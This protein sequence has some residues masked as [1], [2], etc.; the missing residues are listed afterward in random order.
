M[1]GPR[2]CTSQRSGAPLTHCSVHLFRP[3]SAV[4]L[5]VR[6]YSATRSLH[7]CTY[8][9]CKRVCVYACVWVSIREWGLGGW[10][11]VDGVAKGKRSGHSSFN[12][13]PLGHVARWNCCLPGRKD[14]SHLLHMPPFLR[15]QVSGCLLAA[16]H[17][18]A[19]ALGSR[20]GQEPRG[21]LA[22]CRRSMGFCSA[23][24]SMPAPQ[25]SMR[26][27]TV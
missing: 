21:R 9:V 1:Q 4:L 10:Q 27:P 18:F 23:D 6:S 13:H 12:V 17:R 7:V 22:S 26:M 15:Q 14:A 24:W 20:P 25:A 3:S 2:S 8:S 16:A 11:R 5:F 19:A